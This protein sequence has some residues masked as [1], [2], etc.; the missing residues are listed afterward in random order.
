M[1][2]KVWIIFLIW[3]LSNIKLLIISY[4]NHGLNC[5]KKVFHGSGVQFIFSL[6]NSIHFC[7]SA[8][9]MTF[10]I[11]RILL[12]SPNWHM[13]SNSCLVKFL[14]IIVFQILSKC[15][16]CQLNFSFYETQQQ[17]FISNGRFWFSISMSCAFAG[18]SFLKLVHDRLNRTRADG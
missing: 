13:P 1:A 14:F 4:H 7:L 6:Q 5:E 11:F 18:I 2:Y 17:I 9:L 16:K 8:A 10:Y 12:L 3:F 15:F